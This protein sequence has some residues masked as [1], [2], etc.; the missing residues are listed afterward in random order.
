MKTIDWSWITGMMVG[1]EFPSVKEIDEDLLFCMALDLLIVRVV[2]MKWASA[3]E[4]E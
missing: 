2:V 3:Q 4:K 1:I